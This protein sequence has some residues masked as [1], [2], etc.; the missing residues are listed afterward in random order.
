MD[1]VDRQIAI[2]PELRAQA[3]RV[4]IGSVRDSRSIVAL[5]TETGELLGA[6]ETGAPDPVLKPHE[7]AFSKDG[8]TVYATLY[9]NRAYGENDMP[10]H[11]IAVIDLETMTERGRIDLNLYR[12]PHGMVADDDGML[13]VTVEHNRG[14]VVVDPNTGVIDRTI[15][16]DVPTHFV[17]R[18]H[19]GKRMYFAHKEYPFCTAVDVE[20]R[21]ILGRIDLPIGAQ[22]IRVSPDDKWLYIGDFYR[23]LLLVADCES[24]QVDRTAPLHAIPGWPYPTPDGKYVVVTTY[25]EPNDRGYVEILDASDLSVRGVV[26]VGAEPFHPLATPDGKHV[27]VALMDGRIPKI[28]LDDPKIAEDRFKA[29][30]TGAEQLLFL[31]A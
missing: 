5:D 25:D 22:A 18:S 15:F 16:M 17:A 30:G 10:G 27:Y 28:G 23:P 26:E 21:R 2:S 1:T 13:W 6:A 19:N 8:K 12:A 20:T 31:P 14:A 7:I 29:N 4:V 11:E 3:G 9:G 24:L